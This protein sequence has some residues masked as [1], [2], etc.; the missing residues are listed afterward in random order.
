MNEQQIE[1]AGKLQSEFQEG[2][3]KEFLQKNKIKRKVLRKAGV[4]KFKS[5]DEY[6]KTSEELM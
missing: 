3:K 1:V 6:M 4:E 2:L 5:V